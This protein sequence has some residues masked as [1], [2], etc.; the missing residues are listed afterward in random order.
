MHGPTNLSSTI[1]K[2]GVFSWNYASTT[3]SGK[4]S[5]PDRNM[6]GEIG[7]NLFGVEYRG[8]LTAGKIYL[9]C[10]AEDIPLTLRFK[11][12]DIKQAIFTILDLDMNTKTGRSCKIHVE[13]LPLLDPTR[14]LRWREMDVF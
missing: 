13:D 14:K 8:V 11:I 12:Q 4:S 5:V 2:I 1:F 10:T 9:N 3:K 7:I 6:R